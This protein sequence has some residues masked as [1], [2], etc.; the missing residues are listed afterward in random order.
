MTTAVLTG[1]S[2]IAGRSLPGT[3]DALHAIAPDTGEELDPPYSQIDVEQLREAT[4]AAADAFPSFSRLEPEA[5]A[6]FLDS[7]ADEIDALGDAL[8]ERGMRETGL[9]QARLVGERARTTGQL[10]LFA[11]VV[12]SGEHRGVRIDPAQPDRTPLPRV[13]IRQR[14][15]PLGPVAVFGASNFPL[16]F[17]TAGGDT[18]SALAAGCPVVFK[19]HSSH[20]GTSELVASAIARAIATHGLHPG[21]FSHVFGPGRSVGQALVSDPDIHAVGFTGSREGGLA[22]V[23]TAQQRPVPIPVYAEMSSVNPVFILPGALDGDV[24][25]LAAGYVQSA[26]GSSGQLCTQPGIVFVPRGEH[27]DAF[28]RA[29]AEA[30][31][32]ATGQTMLSPSIAAA[33]REGV[34]TRDAHAEVLARGADG[35]GPHAPAPVIHAADLP[36]FD[37]D[38]VLHDEIFGAAS[39]VVRY[40]DVADLVQAASR[41]EGQLTATL[42]LSADDHE[43]ASALL[44]VLERKVGRIL[45]GGWPTGVE[46]GHAMV[47]GG[48]FPATSDSRTTSVG[49]LAIDRFLR[50]VA[51]QNIPDEL[52]PEALRDANPWHVPRLVDGR[53]ES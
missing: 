39:L 32:A 45:A 48:P 4:A 17:S 42:Q 50:P 47:H 3:G 7:I 20:P 44:P 35:E 40:D 51:Y 52:L 10:R 28:L 53:R 19:A 33:W 13:D 27:G 9:P 18:A 38:H 24:Q 8:I 1:H 6:T 36:A 5:H 2:S 29:V 15:I 37:T 43:L 31:N 34:A 41:L 14:R 25:A 11:E 46:V 26:T 12:R 49:T 23:R 22:L 21:V 30:L 16:A